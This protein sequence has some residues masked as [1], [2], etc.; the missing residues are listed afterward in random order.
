MRLKVNTLG[1]SRV[2]FAPHLQTWTLYRLFWLFA[3]L[4]LIFFLYTFCIFLP[5]KWVQNAFTRHTAKE[6]QLFTSNTRT[7]TH[8]FSFLI[9]HCTLC[10]RLKPINIII[11]FLLMYTCRLSPD[12]FTC[13]SAR[14]HFPLSFA[15]NSLIWTEANN[16]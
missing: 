13:T 9:L 5:A 14:I 16:V 15:P 12:S 4:V 3:L 7:F 1:H 6:H 11:V 2:V 10:L 8:A